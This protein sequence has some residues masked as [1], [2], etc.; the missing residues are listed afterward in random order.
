MN[1][2]V[3]VGSTLTKV[4][5]FTNEDLLETHTF[6]LLNIED[7]VTFLGQRR[8]NH[9]IV[10]SVGDFKKEVHD[11]L[12][13]HSKLHILTEKLPIPIKNLYKSSETLGKDRLA[14]VIG[15]NALY[16]NE[17]ILVIDIGT[18]ITYDYIN[19]RNEFIGGAISPGMNIRFKSLNNYTYSLPLVEKQAVK[20]FIGT[21]T[22]ESILS[23]V[24]NGM[25]HEINGAIECYRSRFAHLR[26]IT[27]GGD[28]PFFESYFKS[29]IFAVPNLVLHGLNK[30]LLHNAS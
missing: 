29:T 23:G 5:L 1:L 13:S 3:D 12:H 25:I 28:Q 9:T 10:S 22:K 17:N 6:K 7:L 2:A 21:N 26:V 16:P 18:C 20:K 11:Y 14:G 8:I 4:A 30:I 27:T 19:S 24:V 15:A